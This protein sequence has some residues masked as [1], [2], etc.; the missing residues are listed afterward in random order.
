MGLVGVIRWWRR[1]DA[2]GGGVVVWWC[3]GWWVWLGLVDIVWGGG[4]LGA[5]VGSACAL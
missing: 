1:Y 4:W 5:W 2:G 3:G